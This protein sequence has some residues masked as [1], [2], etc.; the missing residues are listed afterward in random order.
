VTLLD[1]VQNENMPAEK[2]TLAADVVSKV[3]VC[4]PK[5]ETSME[6]DTGELV[7]KE[8]DR[9]GFTNDIA[10]ENTTLVARPV[11]TKIAELVPDPADERHLMEDSEIHS[12]NG[13]T[14]TPIRI[15]LL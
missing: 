14:E 2:P 8:D 4:L 5:T 3:E 1:D 12:E 13:D 6:P 11:V 9:L 10:P 7:I 15:E